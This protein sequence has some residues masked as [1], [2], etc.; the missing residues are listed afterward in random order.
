MW[1]RSASTAAR[2]HGKPKI[3]SQADNMEGRVSKDSTTYFSVPAQSSPRKSVGRE[4][5]PLGLPQSSVRKQLEF[6]HSQLVESFEELMTP[7]SQSQKRLQSND[8]LRAG[9]KRFRG[10]QPEQLSMSLEMYHPLTRNPSHFRCYF[11]DHV[12]I[13]PSLLEMMIESNMDDDCPTDDEQIDAAKD[14]L[15]KRLIKAINSFKP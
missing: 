1:P 9:T 5:V 12:L 2:L 3:S 11:E 6:E 8:S 7:Q 14:Q 13:G 15:G 4:S 10:S